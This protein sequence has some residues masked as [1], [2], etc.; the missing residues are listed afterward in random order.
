MLF[1]QHTF[2]LLSE[3]FISFIGGVLLLA[4][5]LAIQRS[6][7]HKL[8]HEI[9]VKRVDKG[10]LYLSLSVFVWSVL[11]VFMYLGL[12]FQ[13]DKWSVRLV[14]NA[15]S[16][17]NSLFLI[18]ALF[19]FD[20][21]PAYLYNN[22]RST[23]RIIWFLIGL[24][25]VST[26]L[27]VSY[28]DVLDS[29]GIRYSLMP[30]LVL[31]AVLSYFL[32]AALYRTFINRQMFVV[33]GISVLV[34]VLLFLSQLPDFFSMQAYGAY[35]DLIKIIAKTAL[36]SIFLV[37]GTSWVLELSLIPDITHMRIAFTDWNQIVLSIPAKDI[38]E[39]PV[40]F[41]KKTTQFNN[42]LKFAVRRKYAP[43]EEMCIE[44][45]AGGE[46]HSQTYLSRIVEN[47]N[48][49]LALEGDSR[50]H[51]NDL[52]TFI[53]QGRYRLRFLAEHIAIDA[54][55]LTEFSHNAGNQVYR[56]FSVAHK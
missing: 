48:E 45:H 11:A 42:L 30:D 7:S 35:G 44:V 24:S 27:A 28:G 25:V 54:A 19:Y 31:S 37:L 9:S 15:F 10:L 26:L 18:L 49:I 32:M 23:R 39:A 51:R 4:I 3:A 8:S 22:P 6:F 38:I 29:S 52:F 46:I 14:Q 36:I 17:L 21:A 34:I 41:G 56:H 53:G 55:L 16:I 1:D 43:E 13:Y 33:A 50:L 40:E 2:Y 5:W 47:I 12:Y 20:N